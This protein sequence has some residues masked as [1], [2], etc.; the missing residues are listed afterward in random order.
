MLP[1]A[2]FLRRLAGLVLI[3]L[4][5]SCDTLFAQQFLSPSVPGAFS[6][7]AAAR[8][9][10]F[11]RVDEVNLAFSVT[12]K[13]GRF[14]NSLGAGDFQVLDNHRPPHELRV[15]EQQT[16]LPLRV[17]LLIDA[18]DSVKPRFDYEQRAALL[19]LKKILR[20]DE[21]R[22]LLITFNDKVNLLNDWTGDIST[23]QR[24]IRQARAGGSTA[25]Y[26][27]VVFASGKLVH[28]SE[29]LVTRKIIV[30][31]SDGVDTISHSTM[32]DA[33]QAA[34]RSQALMLALST[35]NVMFDSHPPG[36]KVL[37]LL[38]HPTGGYLLAAHEDWQLSGAFAKIQRTLRNQYFL[39]Y[40]PANFA[41]D[42]T[43]RPI[44][45]IPRNPKLRVQRRNGYY[46]RWEN[47]AALK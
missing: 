30:L 34:A 21:D 8:I 35:N 10:I 28:T 12:D 38:T 31:I 29:A 14:I 39:A 2:R 5:S 11:R 6:G 33:Q 44:D 13:K 1:V 27:A 23:V 47:P 16:E 37:D 32:A 43:Y 42:G 46:A 17:G 45:L 26:D 4:V 7:S 20:P 18:S 15:F 9:T 22:A 25:L 19:F 40:Q 24:S 3:A 41:P 36:E